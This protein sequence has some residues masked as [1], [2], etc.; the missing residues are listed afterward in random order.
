M[1]NFSYV[2]LISGY[3]WWVTKMT[4]EVNCRVLHSSLFKVFQCM[5]CTTIFFKWYYRRPRSTYESLGAA[6]CV[7]ALLWVFN[8]PAHQFAELAAKDPNRESVDNKYFGLKIN[9]ILLFVFLLRPSLRSPE[10]CSRIND[11]VAILVEIF[12]LLPFIKHSCYIQHRCAGYLSSI[13]IVYMVG[14]NQLIRVRCLIPYKSMS[15]IFAFSF[16]WRWRTLCWI[17]ITCKCAIP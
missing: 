10:R 12:P 4:I 2:N 15:I 5:M 11:S 17:V 6:F 8:L 14:H 9:L 13:W 7:R 3:D 16:M 1:F